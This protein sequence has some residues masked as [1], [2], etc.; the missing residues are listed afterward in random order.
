MGFFF[1]PTL[2]KA[3]NGLENH[4]KLTVGAEREEAHGVL[5]G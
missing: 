5:C 1:M 4:Q 2:L 3:K